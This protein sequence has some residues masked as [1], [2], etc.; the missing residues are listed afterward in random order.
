MTTY[1]KAGDHDTA[2]FNEEESARFVI[3]CMTALL[4]PDGYAMYQ[5]AI[6]IEARHSL[7]RA[8][9]IELQRILEANSIVGIAVSEGKAK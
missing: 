8:A 3:K 2:P 5:S 7:A 9:E 1:F 6:K 4:P